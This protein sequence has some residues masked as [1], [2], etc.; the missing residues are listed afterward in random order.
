MRAVLATAYIGIF[1]EPVVIILIELLAERNSALSGLW[2]EG[3][4]CI[5]WALWVTVSVVV[6]SSGNLWLGNIS[7]CL[8]QKLPESVFAGSDS[9]MHEELS[10]GKAQLCQ[11]S[12]HRLHEQ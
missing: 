5:A 10:W 3:T 8:L 4:S 2:V 9:K 6:C 12:S 11:A 7:F 1:Q